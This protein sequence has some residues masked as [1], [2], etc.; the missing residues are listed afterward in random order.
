MKVREQLKVRTEWIVRK[1]LDKEHYLSDKPPY[2]TV[3]I[4]GNLGLNSGLNEALKLIGTTGATQFNNANAHIVIGDND[5]SEWAANTAYVLGDRVRDVGKND[6]YIYECTTAGTSHATT[7]PT[8]VNTEGSTTADN[9]V[10]WTTHTQAAN[11]AQTHLNGANQDIL[12]METGY[13]TLTDQTLTFRGVADGSTANQSWQE[14]AITNGHAYSNKNYTAKHLNR[15]ISDQGTKAS[16]QV[17]T[18]DGAVTLA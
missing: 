7:E 12:D 10:V 13:P 17:W 3:T 1:Y 11:A 2:K 5:A 14:F 6:A 4:K 18:V 16:G 9:T 8:W 15:K